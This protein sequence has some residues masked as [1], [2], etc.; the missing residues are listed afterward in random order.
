MRE[1][2]LNAVSRQ[3]AARTTN[4]KAFGF[5][6]TRKSAEIAAAIV[7]STTS[8]NSVVLDPFLGS[9]STALGIAKLRS[10]RL[11]IG[12][13]L[14][15]MPIVNLKFSLGDFSD[16]NL[17]DFSR[18]QADL[19]AI[20][21]NYRFETKAGMFEVSKVIHQVTESRLKPIS[22]IGKFDGSSKQTKIPSDSPEYSEL[23]EQYE[24]KLISFPD[25]E[26]PALEA[27]SRIAIKEGMRVAD[28]FGPL[29]FESLSSLKSKTN[30]SLLYQLVIASGL[31]LCRLTDA[32]SQ[33]QFPFWFPKEDI[34]EKSV[35]QVLEKK[36]FEIRER[37]EKINEQNQSN[38]VEK[39]SDWF[40]EQKSGHLLLLGNAAK[41]MKHSIPEKVV[42]LVLT[43]PPYFD[44]VAYS[45]YLKLW[46]HFTGFESNLDEEIVESSRV[47]AQKTREIFLQDLAKAF[48]EVN[49][50][51]K[52][53]SFALV[54][55][56]D[57]KPAN[58]HDFIFCLE[59][60]GL[61]Y[62][63]QLHL[64]KATYTYKQNA[65][66]ENTV[67]GDSIMIFQALASASAEAP[68]SNQSIEELDQYFLDLFQEYLE[69][70]GPATLT[71]ALDNFLIEKLYRRGYLS[72]IKNSG[73]F[74][75]ISATR[76]ILDPA[77]RKWSI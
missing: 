2:V 42:D 27:N 38:P 17:S 47:G 29:G 8:E 25:R 46:E 58:L 23:V 76:F 45:E 49:R 31:H 44:Q 32:K 14:N 74:S 39:F 60:V 36:F 55:F 73:H 20:R 54:Y 21:E 53:G 5:Y 10:K 7:E 33:S 50:V 70:N 71:E 66:Q 75:K 68:S 24:S 37:V 9:G 3:L 56:K 34:H 41:V 40:D 35:Y 15:E 18:L 11:F 65:S 43:D 13:E 59:S 64:S 51:M 72:K 61:K 48:S 19:L 69:K 57:S 4:E 1:K 12:V 52:T 16:L 30:E 77:T 62:V 6:W 28:V 22:F 67:G 26:S 63:S